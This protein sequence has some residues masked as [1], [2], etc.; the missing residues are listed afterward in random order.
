MKVQAG[1]QLRKSNPKCEIKEIVK[2]DMSPAVVEVEYSMFIFS[3]SLS[4]LNVER[5]RLNELHSGR[6]EICCRSSK[7][8]MAR[9]D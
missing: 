7:C 2:E 6:L 5:S 1:N 3:H 4:L 8:Q 9:F